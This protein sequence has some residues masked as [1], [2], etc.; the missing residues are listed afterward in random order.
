MES[1]M[2][3]NIFFS[4]VGGQGLVLANAITSSA[5]LEA[6]LDVK[7]SDIYGLAMR[8]GA[9]YGFHRHGPR[10]LTSTFAAGQG[11]ILVAIEPL[12]GLRWARMM[13]RGAVA[14]VNTRP[15][16]PSP[17][18]LEKAA[19][20]LDF[21]ERLADGGLIVKAVDAVGMAQQAGTVRAANTVLLGMLSA[22]L[23]HIPESCWTRALEIHLGNKRFE[24]N[25]VA[26]NSG[27]SIAK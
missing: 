19:Y 21:A 11:D 20:P 6:G 7:T 12:E 8:G 24:E 18:L 13:R 17:V 9:L 23:P 4:G 14:I 26:F 15:V 27:R 22:Q 25:L 10:V 16:L 3:S 1:N 2:V 5:A